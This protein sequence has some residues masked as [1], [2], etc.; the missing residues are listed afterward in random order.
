MMDWFPNI[1]ENLLSLSL[2]SMHHTIVMMQKCVLFCLASHFFS[3]NTFH[4]MLQSLCSISN[5]EGFK[6]FV[7]RG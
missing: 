2:L 7:P 6:I 1:S 3:T 5:S 4:H